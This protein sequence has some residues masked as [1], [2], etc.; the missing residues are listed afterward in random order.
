MTIG[1][2]YLCVVCNVIGKPSASD[3]AQ[4][5]VGLIPCVRYFNFCMMCVR[6]FIFCMGFDVH[7][8]S[9]TR[10]AYCSGHRSELKSKRS[11]ESL[12]LGVGR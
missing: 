9:S 5:G 4:A 6:Y 12:N 10:V 2:A 1:A 7:P 8:E 11:N 3:G